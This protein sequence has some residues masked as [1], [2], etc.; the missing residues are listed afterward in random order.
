M[1]TTEK[2]LVLI[3]DD[4]PK[5]VQYLGNLLDLRGYRI[6]Y[7]TTGDKA[8]QI[9]QATKPD[10]I[11][12][13]VV[14]PDINGF[15]LCEKIKADEK[16][17]HIPVLFLTCKVNLKEKIHGFKAGGADYIVKPFEEEEIIAR[18]ETHLELKNSF[19]RLTLLNAT[20]D[21]F[22]SIIA[23]DLRNPFSSI[24]GFIQLMETDYDELTEDEKKLFIKEIS[25]ISKNA[26][27]LLEQLLQWAV[28]QTNQVKYSSREISLKESLENSINVIEGS[29]K[30]KNISIL[31]DIDQKHKVSCDPVL[32]ETIIRN[33][34]SNAVKFSSEHTHIDI[35][36]N[37]TD[38]D[39]KISVKDYGV[40]MSQED[41][42]KLF[43]IDVNTTQIGKTKE[44]GSG[45][46]LIL[47]KELLEICN[48]KID[49]E[50]TKGQ[51]SVF[52]VTLPIN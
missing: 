22:F 15:D 43:R 1:N 33:L 10:I 11:L 52:T 6:S 34:L 2:P 47:C 3:V 49:V 24:S 18:V 41:L 26:N 37:K 48:G 16:L 9:L 27:N 36:A 28:I 42:R 32:F 7:A 39:M 40:G 17:F 20:K 44:K 13:D 50:S 14:L 51:G 4:E 46:G 38:T 45:L 35:D 21:K 12:L 25:K 31:R 23:H 19:E 8:L 30:I 29:A 5:S